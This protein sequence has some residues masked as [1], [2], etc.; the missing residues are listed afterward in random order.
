[1]A[2]FGRPDAELEVLDRG[3]R[4]PAQIVD[5]ASRLLPEIA[6]GLGVPTSARTAQGSLEV[7]AAEDV[8]NAVAERSRAA[9]AEPGSIGVIAADDDV[10]GIYDRLFADDLDVSLLGGDEDALEIA[11][12]V[13]VPAT[14]AK[15]LEFETVIVVEPAH[16][17][18]AE[19]RGYH[20][21]YVVLTRAVS[22]LHIIHNEPLPELL[23]DN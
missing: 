14:L 19:A 17:V 8:L 4:V 13:C 20:R 23:R 9:L 11:R 10:I 21:L 7:A 6:R 5:Y 16:I 2:H 15:G 12:L 18:S 22:A 3:Y 1:L